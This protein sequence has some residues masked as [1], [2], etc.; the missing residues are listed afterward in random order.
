MLSVEQSILKFL[1][2]YA[3]SLTKQ[4][5]DKGVV[6]TGASAESLKA[7]AREFY[8]ALSGYS[9]WYQ[10]RYGRRPGKMPPVDA[11]IEWIKTK[12]TLKV[13]QSNPKSVESFAWAIAKSIAKKG[14]SAFTNKE[15]R[16]QVPEKE[17]QSMREQLLR[18]LSDKFVVD[19]RTQI[20][21]I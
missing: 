4:Q 17:F 21:K 10:Q 16:V 8:G 6:N 19:I 12:R 7:T 13:D 2:R 18:D 14:T 11:I 15:K 1:T 20:K 9:Y 3:E 5:R